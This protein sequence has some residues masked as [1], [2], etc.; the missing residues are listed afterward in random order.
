MHPVDVFVG[1]R[2]AHLRQAHGLSQTALGGLIGV[3]F[4]QVQKYERGTNRVGAS[5][6]HAIAGAL[7][8]P[9]QSFFP[10]ATTSG[11]APAATTLDTIESVRDPRVRRALGRLID[12]LA[13]A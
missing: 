7:A 4:Q 13:A 11:T 1:A 8:A 6:L 3:T 10:E 2:I 12:A 9:V 5:R